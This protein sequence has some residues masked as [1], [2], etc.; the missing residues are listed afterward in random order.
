MDDETNN[1]VLGEK[2]KKNTFV[3]RKKL[4]LNLFDYVNAKKPQ[5][6]Y[7]SVIFLIVFLIITVVLIISDRATHACS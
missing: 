3:N 6:K 2:K 1:C 5:F 7:A 4:Y